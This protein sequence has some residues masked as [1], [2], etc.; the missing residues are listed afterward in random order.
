MLNLIKYK[1]EAQSKYMIFEEKKI[2]NGIGKVRLEY[3][4]ARRKDGM[5]S[6]SIGRCGRTNQS[7]MLGTT[8]DMNGSDLS[9]I[10]RFW[11]PIGLKA[12]ATYRCLDGEFEVDPASGFYEGALEMSLG[13]E[14]KES[15]GI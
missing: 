4:K 12:Y 15:L 3:K 1:A 9:R 8:N 10:T 13:R 11:C 14:R 6:L 5:Q 7:P 2:D